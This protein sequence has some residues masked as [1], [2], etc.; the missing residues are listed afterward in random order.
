MKYLFDKLTENIKSHDNVILMTH[1]RPDLDGLGSCIALAKI[2]ESMKKEAFIIYPE[3]QTNV[4]L[5]KGIK[6]CLDKKIKINFLCE[7]EIE[8]QIKDN[9]LL[10]IL[11]TQKPELVENEKLLEL[12]KDIF[13][14]DH[15]INSSSHIEKAIFEYINSN[16]SSIAEIIAN[17]IKYLNKTI[18]NV[19]LTL[20][21]AGMEIDTNGY[22]LK[23]SEDTFKAAAYL[24]KIGADNYLKQEILKSSRE[25]FI[26]SHDCIK[27]SYYI[28]DKYLMCEMPD[29]IYDSVD[30]AIVADEMLR[31][32][33]V[34][35]S[36]S[37]GKINEDVV[38]VSARSMGKVSVGILMS[39]I[40]GG[41]HITDAAA[42]IKNKT[43]KEVVEMIKNVI[44]E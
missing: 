44:K 16:K 17:Y 21:L 5:E 32:S 27:N 42:Q 30:L 23:T 25:D 36:F 12:I 8:K 1:K 43:I 37:V 41:G 33:D 26:R 24:T 3:K 4:S 19:I 31:F 28:K 11:D 40:G 15:H 14:I 10:I 18:D 35:V 34:E 39:A 29:G 6:A 20:L 38:G 13:V 2:I 7:K 22:N 9:T